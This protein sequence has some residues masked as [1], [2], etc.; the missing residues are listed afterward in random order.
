MVKFEDVLSFPML[1]A[2]RKMT[3]EDKMTSTELENE[4]WSIQKELEF[5]G[6]E[7]N[8]SFDGQVLWARQRILNDKFV[9]L[10]DG[11]ISLI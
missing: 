2:L 7:F 1:K 6:A 5:K 3:D 10:N 9:D 11:L 4:F 8:E